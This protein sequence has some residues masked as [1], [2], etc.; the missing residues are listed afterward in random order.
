M[1]LLVHNARTV[2]ADG[3]VR[4]RWVYAADGLIA[5]VGHGGGWRDRPDF[6]LGS[7]TG[8]GHSTQVVDAG[9][10]TLVP[11]FI[12]LHAHGGG[13]HRFEDGLPELEAALTT[14][15]RHG[16]TRSVVSLASSDL[17]S[18]AR[19]LAD[20]AGLARRDG[21]VLGSHLEGPYLSPHRCGAH[22]PAALRV[23]ELDE[24]DALV[25]A[26]E[27]TLRQVTI[28]PELPGALPAIS[29]LTSEGVVCAVGH[30]DADYARARA[31]FDAGATLL[32]HAY[33]AMPGIG[34]RAPG[35]VV[36]A[37]DDE[38]V[39]LEIINDG[40]HIDPRVVAL[41]FAAARG[42]VAMVSDAMAA[43]GLGDGVY[44]LGG[45][46]VAVKGGVARLT[47][48]TSLA[49]STVTLGQS[50]PRAIAAGVSEIETVAAVT[51]VPAAALGLGHRFGR[52]RV[53]YAA[54]LVLLDPSWA[55]DR[56]FS[57]GTEVS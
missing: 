4:D 42:R 7:R 35:P 14:H 33:N 47:G 6:D 12:D 44:R 49:G 34:H 54:D 2:D 23:P 8:V 56:V 52:V 24:V 29:R 39:Y 57:D 40:Q 18:T 55:V 51:S 53:G 13:G 20:V 15:R 16:T 11:G 21:R 26:A 41:T 3:I 5:A 19:A 46:E 25:R 50:L 36:A 48:S 27:G 43:A 37:F 1:P 32:T 22:D 10:N 45:R 17:Q 28:A 38:R 31:A 30:T 9:G